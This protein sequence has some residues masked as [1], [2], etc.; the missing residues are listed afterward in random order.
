[1]IDREEDQHMQ[2]QEAASGETAVVTRVLDPL[3]VVVLIERAYEEVH[4]SA[5]SKTRI[6]RHDA[7]DV[8]TLQ[9]AVRL[10]ARFE[11]DSTGQRP[12]GLPT[13]DESSGVVATEVEPAP[14]GEGEVTYLPRSAMSPSWLPKPRERRGVSDEELGFTLPIDVV[15][16]LR[17][18]MGD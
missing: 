3:T 12:K 11:V 2:D 15:S 8:V 16:P 17:R 14:R 13:V 1:M 18:P 6:L 7:G 9:E 5:R 4:L 10:G